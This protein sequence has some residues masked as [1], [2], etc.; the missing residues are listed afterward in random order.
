MTYGRRRTRDL[1]LV[2]P[3]RP[4]ASCGCLFQPTEKRRMLCHDCYLSGTP[5][6]RHE[7]REDRTGSRERASREP[8]TP[9]NGIASGPAGRAGF[10]DRRPGSHR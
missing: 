3:K 2:R 1:P 7:V 9:T 6:W 4:C 5:K 8:V 10:S